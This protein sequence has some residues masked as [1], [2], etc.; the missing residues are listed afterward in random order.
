M[1]NNYAN[2]LKKEKVLVHEDSLNALYV[3]FTRARDNLFVIKKSKDSMFDILDMSVGSSGSLKCASQTSVKQKDEN[4][5]KLEY[6]SLSYGAQSDILKLE[7]EEDE[8]FKAQNFGLAL[9]YM[10]EMMADFN[11]GSILDAKNIMINKY[12]YMLDENEIEDVVFRVKLLTQ[13][14][15][16]KNLI[17]GERYK[18][19]AL[20]YKDNLRYIDLLIKQESGKWIVI[21]YKSSMAYSEHHLKQVR[22]Y[23][24]AIKEITNDEVDGYICYLLQDSIKIIQI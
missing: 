10:L 18:E 4:Q 22:Y 7:D 5:K 14:E 20:R 2:A 17:N 15:E 6:Q 24:K 11:E 19:K 9:H 1:D 3:A 8:D 16:F 23:A 13:N 21:D 12:G